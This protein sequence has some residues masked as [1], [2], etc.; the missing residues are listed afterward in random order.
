MYGLTPS[1]MVTEHLSFV[2]PFMSGI[3]VMIASG[4]PNN[5]RIKRYYDFIGRNVGRLLLG[6]P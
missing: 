5:G 4:N 3:T 2:S 1:Y 6:F